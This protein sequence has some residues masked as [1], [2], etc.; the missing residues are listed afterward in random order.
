M[1]GKRTRSSE[2]NGQPLVTSGDNGEQLEADDD[3]GPMPNVDNGTRKKRK[4]I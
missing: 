1:L 4:G 2:A 3:I